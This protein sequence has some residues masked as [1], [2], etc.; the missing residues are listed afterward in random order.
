MSR[1]VVLTTDD[2]GT[3]RVFGPVEDE[4]FADRLAEDAA[5]HFASVGVLVLTS[6]RVL[7]RHLSTKEPDR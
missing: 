2:D 7:V 4:R 6:A 3:E 1:Y 5:V